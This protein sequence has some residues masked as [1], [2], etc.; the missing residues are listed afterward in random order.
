MYLYVEIF[1]YVP[2]PLKK[3]SIAVELPG[4]LLLRLPE[5][6]PPSPFRLAQ[7]LFC[8]ALCSP[9]QQSIAFT[10]AD[11]YLSR[12][13][14]PAQQISPGGKHRKREEHTKKGTLL[15]LLYI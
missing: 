13:Y 8:W 10:G 11:H 1:C 9:T 2:Y 3:T 5:E 14:S 6:Q 12:D 15:P 7:D 4:T